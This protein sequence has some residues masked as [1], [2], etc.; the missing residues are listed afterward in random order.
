MRKLS[1]IIT[2]QK[3]SRRQKVFSC[4]ALIVFAVFLYWPTLQFDFVL[5]D[6]LVITQNG[7][8]QGGQ[9][10]L[11]VIWAKNSKTFQTTDSDEAKISRPLT[12]TYFALVYDKGIP[13]EVLA[14]HYHKGQILLYSL[15]VLSLFLFLEKYFT[16]LSLGLRCIVI[17][18]FVAHPLHVEVVANIKSADELLASI[19][20]VLSLL[21]LPQSRAASLQEFIQHSLLVLMSFFLI[22]LGYKAKQ[23]ILMLAPINMGI[24]LFG[25]LTYLSEKHQKTLD[26]YKWYIGVPSLLSLLGIALYR[27]SQNNPFIQ[28]YARDFDFYQTT[29]STYTATQNT[30]LGMSSTSE[31]FANSLWTTLLSVKNLLYPTQLIHQ[32]GAYQIPLTSWESP[33]PYMALALALCIIGGIFYLLKRSNQKR[34]TWIAIGIFI[35]PLI[36]YSHIFIPL[37]DTYADRFLF[38]AVL[39]FLLLLAVTSTEINLKPTWILVTSLLIGVGYTAKSVQRIP[40]W[41]SDDTLL[42][43]DFRQSPNNASIIARYA[44]NIEKDT[45]Q[46][47]Q[48]YLEA[49]AIY[50]NFCGAHQDIGELYFSKRAYGKSLHHFKQAYAINPKYIYIQKLSKVNQAQN[51]LEMAVKLLDSAQSTFPEEKG[52]SLYQMNAFDLLKLQSEMA[53]NQNNLASAISFLDSALKIFP[54][55][56]TTSL[57]QMNAFDLLKLQS[58]MAYHQDNLPSAITSLDSALDVFPGS[59]V[60]NGYRSNTITLAQM[61][62]TQGAQEKAYVLLIKALEQ[63]TSHLAYAQ[64]GLNMAYQAENLSRAVEFGL[65]FAP[66]RA[67]DST[68]WTDLENLAQG[69]EILL[70]RI[71]LRKSETLSVR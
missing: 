3:Y 11:E 9:D 42:T 46:K 45:V 39:G 35:L 66:S 60:T 22:Y 68:Y 48:L 38:M 47:E 40:A 65:Y 24:V 25:A 8:T 20:F 15:L 59:K 5:D 21:V 31:I 64:E 50:P 52:T 6:K 7:V 37:P 63:D 71:K 27:G 49:L 41:Q 36:A 2:R 17:L 33:K 51:N 43:E 30:F 67:D 1:S 14:N 10:S 53:Y 29:Q 58:E 18:L 4:V 12:Q 54:G 56:R 19:C 61:Y 69:N 44:S 55:D 23:N 70:E 62:F 32:Y 57:Y 16:H 26:N 28:F 34:S 13:Q